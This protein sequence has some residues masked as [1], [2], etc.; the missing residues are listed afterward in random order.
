MKKILSILCCLALGYYAQAQ[1][2]GPATNSV[3]P[4]TASGTPGLTPSFFSMPCIDSGSY[5]LDTLYFENYTSYYDSGSVYPVNYLKIDSITNLPSGLCWTSN[6]TNNQW[7]GGQTGVIVISG[8]CMAT[9]GQY[10]L[11]IVVD[12]NIGSGG[13]FTLSQMNADHIT[14]N[15]VQSLRYFLR[16]REPG[17]SCAAVDTNL[18]GIN[19]LLSATINSSG[20]V[21]CNSNTVTLTANSCTGCTYAWSNFATSQ[22]T[23]VSAAGTYTVTITQGAVTASSAI[24]ISQGSSLVPS[25]TLTEDSAVSNL[26]HT[27]NTSTGGGIVSYNWTWGDNTGSG[28]SIYSPSHL[29][30]TQGVF[31]VCLTLYDTLGCNVTHCDSTSL[32]SVPLPAQATITH[33]LLVVCNGAPVTLTADFCSGCTYLWSNAATT[34]SINVTGAGPYSVTISDGMHSVSATSPAIRIDT[35]N[36]TYTLT[37]D[38]ANSSIWIADNTSTGTFGT[39]FAYWTWGDGMGNADTL[40]GA[41]H[42]YTTP[43]VHT[44]CLDVYDSVGC[45]IS[46][47]DSSANTTIPLPSTATITESAQTICNGGSV[48]L[49]ADFCSGCTYLWSNSATGQSISVST[50]GSYTVTI[51]AGGQ[52]VSSSAVTLGTSTVVA[53]FSLVQDT[54]VAHHW[55]VVNNCVNAQYYLWSWGDGSYDSSAAPLHTYAAAG[56]YSIC[57]YVQNASGCSAQYCDSST[58]LSRSEAIISVQVLPVRANGI[59]DISGDAN[60]QVYPSPGT[61]SLTIETPA[62]IQGAVVYDALGRSL[63]EISLTSAKTTVDLSDLSTGVYTLSIRN[64]KSVRFVIAK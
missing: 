16:V 36:V 62:N 46:H 43:G 17:A 59:N 35:I 29:Y 53:S 49:T 2:C 56:V 50:A 10:K 14:G 41:T 60:I 21:I 19:V 5:V 4:H 47:C 22:S 15:P 44:V 45:H 8:V 58:Y 61:G 20:N 40:F 3:T 54:N 51:S 38:S 37:Q 64:G 26:W 9:T 1:H 39:T 11:G 34:Q 13:G 42:Q 24:H 27:D 28:D 48:I 55:F 32:T 52:S 23:Q 6:V 31:T 63:R 18:G 12:L 30:T 7:T 33:S 25:F 57:V